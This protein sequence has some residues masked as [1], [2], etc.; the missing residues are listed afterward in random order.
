[1]EK[2]TVVDLERYERIITVMISGL[3][4]LYWVI[5]LG[6]RYLR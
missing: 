6:E 2:V 3:F 4:Y 5:L 1:M